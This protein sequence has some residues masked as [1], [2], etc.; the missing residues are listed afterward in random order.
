MISVSRI[1]QPND[2]KLAIFGLIRDI[3]NMNRRTKHLIDRVWGT[4]N[5]GSCH[6]C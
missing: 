2:L 5:Q 4:R 6:K 3:F 1:D